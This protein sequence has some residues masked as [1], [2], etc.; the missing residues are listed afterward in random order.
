MSSTQLPQGICPFHFFHLTLLLMTISSVNTV[1]VLFNTSIYDIN[2]TLELQNDL[3]Y[4][5]TGN[6]T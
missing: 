6:K 1:N 3:F 4:S 2:G 5:S